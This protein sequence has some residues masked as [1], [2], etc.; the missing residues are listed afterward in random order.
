MNCGSSAFNGQT[1]NTRMAQSNITAL[2]E[3]IHTTR[4]HAANANPPFR[5]SIRV[6][7]FQGWFLLARIHSERVYRKQ[8]H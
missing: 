7:S 1:H 4:P 8:P 5:E 6:Q 3:T 2:T